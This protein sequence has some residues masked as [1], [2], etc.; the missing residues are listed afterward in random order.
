MF[1]AYLEELIGFLKVIRVTRLVVG[2]EV[3]TR[4]LEVLVELR[5]LSLYGSIR[6]NRLRP[7]VRYFREPRRCPFGADLYTAMI[8]SRPSWS[9]V[10]KHRFREP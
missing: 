5:A 10:G 2:L 8:C 9:S 1:K 3:L 6:L 7:D 4:P